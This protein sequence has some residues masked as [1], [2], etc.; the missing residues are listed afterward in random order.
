MVT[1]LLSPASCS[2][3]LAESPSLCCFL[4]NILIYPYPLYHLSLLC[5]YISPLSTEIMNTIVFR[6]DNGW[7]YLPRNPSPLGSKKILIGCS[8]CHFPC[9]ARKNSH[10]CMFYSKGFT[11]NG[12]DFLPCN[13]IYHPQCIKVGPP[14]SVLDTMEKG[15]KVYSILLWL[16]ST[17]SFVNYAPPG[18]N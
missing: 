4:G 17:P 13:V 16:P 11:C 1:Y 15:Q 12:I 2:G 5:C 3:S 10:K 18:H 14:P 8:G 6:K 9:D 7:T